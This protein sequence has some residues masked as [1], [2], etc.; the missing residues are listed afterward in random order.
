V[1]DICNRIISMEAAQK[2]ADS[3]EAI[4]KMA[5]PQ[6]L[7]AEFARTLAPIADWDLVYANLQKIDE[8]ERF[9]TE[10]RLW[11]RNRPE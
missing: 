9:S 8:P 11:L 3:F 7:P 4:L 2:P 1:I 6:V 5:E 10:V